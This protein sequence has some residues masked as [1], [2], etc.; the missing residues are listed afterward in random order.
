MMRT[1]TP[2]SATDA[3]ARAIASVAR[4]AG[5]ECAECTQGRLAAILRTLWPHREGK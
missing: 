5:D 1:I 3:S 2:R 4:L